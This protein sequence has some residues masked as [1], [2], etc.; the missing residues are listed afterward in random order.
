MLNEFVQVTETT[1]DERFL[2]NLSD[3]SYI[4]EISESNGSLVRLKSKEKT[5]IQVKESF[6]SFEEFF[7][8]LNSEE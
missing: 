2:I 7:E 6:E 3:I 1:T 8:Q 4:R 5:A